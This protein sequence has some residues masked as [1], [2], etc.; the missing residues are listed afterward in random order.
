M[1]IGR[2]GELQIENLCIFLRLLEAVVGK[3]VGRLCLHYS[4][5]LICTIK[6]EVVSSLLR[7]PPGST[8]RNDDPPVSKG[9][10]FADQLVIPPGRVEFRQNECPAGIGFAWHVE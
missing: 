5:H 8:T 6:E 3:A 9:S 7:A 10:L 1:A 4:E 2:V